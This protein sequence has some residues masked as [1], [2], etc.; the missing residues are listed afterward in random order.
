MS[1]LH[2]IEGKLE[3]AL[4]I[5]LEDS[6]AEA[7][8]EGVTITTGFADETILPPFIVCS[9]GQ[10]SGEVGVIGNFLC[11]ASIMVVGN[12][13][14]TPLATHRALVAEVRDVMLSSGL[15]DGISQSVDGFECMGEQSNITTSTE[16]SEGRWQSSININ[17][18]CRCVASE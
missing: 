13:E 4:K 10:C 12:A 11:A 3:A 5:V 7:D 15:P 2:D 1:A 17:L 8:L 6:I 18:L 16:R 14:D 9:V